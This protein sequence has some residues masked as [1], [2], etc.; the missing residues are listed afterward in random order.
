MYV[1]VLPP[2]WSVTG[3]ILSQKI[4]NNGF[5]EYTLLHPVTEVYIG[6]K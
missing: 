5:I 6:I 3:V 4:L 1:V 2:N